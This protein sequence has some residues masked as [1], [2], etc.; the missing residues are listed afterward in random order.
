[1]T[2]FYL[3]R[4]QPRFGNLARHS[5]GHL[6]ALRIVYT[7]HPHTTIQHIRL[8]LDLLQFKCDHLA[9]IRNPIVATGKG[10]PATRSLVIWNGA[11][12]KRVEEPESFKVGNVLSWGEKALQVEG[13]SLVIVVVNPISTTGSGYLRIPPSHPHPS[14][15]SFPF[16]FVFLFWRC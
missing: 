1:M 14:L 3:F 7:V 9:H 16:V 8:Y 13:L 5:A 2:R 15:R 4:P 10:Y 12:G 11:C 6:G